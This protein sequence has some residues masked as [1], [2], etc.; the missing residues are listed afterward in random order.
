MTRTRRWARTFSRRVQSMV[1]LLRTVVA[2]SRAMSRR[3]GV[4]EN[5]DGAVVG[6]QRV[7]EGEFVVVEAEFFAATLGLAHLFGEGDE[8]LDDLRRLDGAVLVAVDAIAPA[9]RRRSGPGRRWRRD[10]RLISSVRSLR[11]SSTARFF[12]GIP[13]TS[14]RNSSERMEMSGFSR[15]AAA[16]MSTTP[17]E[18]MARGDQ[19]GGW[20]GPSGRSALTRSAVSLARAARTAW[21]KATSSRSAGGFLV[22][23]GKGES[24]EQVG[25]G[26]GGAGPCRRAGR[27]CA[28]GRGQQS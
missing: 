3:V 22:G 18:A 14:A 2:S 15:P 17:S 25:H 19:S 7:V 21:K 12:W 27:G 11:S 26:A 6:L 16:K 9:S 23:H 8:F 28:P 4:A 10:G 5:L 1:T 20:R 13:R 24:C